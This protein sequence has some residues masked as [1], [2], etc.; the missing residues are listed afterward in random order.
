MLYKQDYLGFCSFFS[1]GNVATRNC[2]RVEEDQS[3]I[4][5]F[6]TG[7]TRG[8]CTFQESDKEKSN[9]WVSDN[10][11]GACS[12]SELR[13]SNNIPLSVV[14]GRRFSLWKV[15]ETGVEFCARTLR[16][17]LGVWWSNRWA[18]IINLKFVLHSYVIFCLIK[19][20]LFFYF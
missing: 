17:F 15:P 14:V 8:T 4:L 6:S 5:T 13:C 1:A 12:G 9:C 10:F 19:V 11:E 3:C 18:K 16:K 2:H 20:I 7:I